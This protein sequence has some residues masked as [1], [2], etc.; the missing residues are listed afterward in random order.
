MEKIENEKK[1]NQFNKED[2]QV[3]AGANCV[4]QKFYIDPKFSKLPE[5]IQEEIQIICVTLSEKLGC[6]FLMGFYE[7]GEVYF[8]TVQF[9]DDINF[10]HIGSELEIKRV[11]KLHKE[12]IESLTLWY[13]VVILGNVDML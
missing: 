5:Q 7:D 13:Q 3:I 9:E 12:L 4:D 2:K 11:V 1:I 8:E 6:I 10:D